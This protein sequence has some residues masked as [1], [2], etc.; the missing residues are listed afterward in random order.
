MLNVKSHKDETFIERD[1]YDDIL[2][3]KDNLS[4]NT[5]LYVTGSRQVG[6]TYLLHKFGTSEY[7]QFLEL[8]LATGLIYFYN[9]GDE[10]VVIDSSLQKFTGDIYS[11]ISNKC[12]E[13]TNSKSSCLF[14][15]EIQESESVYNSI[16]ALVRY[17][18]F[19]LIVTGS[20][21]GIT[22][23]ERFIAPVGD[24]EI[25]KLS[26]LKFS[27]FEKAVGHMFPNRHTIFLKYLEVG[28]YPR[29]TVDLIN[30][31]SPKHKVF[32]D[33]IVKMLLQE[34]TRYLSDIKFQNSINELFNGVVLDLLK[35]KKGIETFTMELSKRLES[36]ERLN[37]KKKDIVSY[38]NWLTEAGIV[39]YASMAVG[40]NFNLIV[41][42]KRIYFNDVIFINYA[43]QQGIDISALKG[44]RLETYAFKVLSD[45]SPISQPV[46]CT[47]PSTSG[48]LDFCSL[49]LPIHNKIYGFEI[50]SADSPY[51]TGQAMLKE[52]LID[53]LIVFRADLTEE[54]IHNLKDGKIKL[55]PL[56]MMEE[57]IQYLIDSEDSN[58]YHK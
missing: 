22:V 47:H 43:S 53:E 41:E 8:N 26:T 5:A 39:S 38:M 37:F 25:I 18:E 10:S 9:E 29:N 6:K 23:N 20:Y 42:R 56:F 51:K 36:D 3:W 50:K 48:E 44:K 7:N 46:F 12:P 11:Y 28:G 24:V 57:Y 33:S 32:G 58:T 27:E 55:V 4:N 49:S 34:T 45:A 14:I 35:D 2:Y 40:C 17:T 13:F 21:L 1:I 52:N 30:N 15:D 16:R 19:G 54:K 31:I